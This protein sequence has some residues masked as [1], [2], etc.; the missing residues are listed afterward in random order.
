[1][2]DTAQAKFPVFL[3]FCL[4]ADVTIKSYRILADNFKS[5]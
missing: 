2:Y 1:M 3:S 4:S 5:V